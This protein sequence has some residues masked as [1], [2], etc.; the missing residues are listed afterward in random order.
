MLPKRALR[1]VLTTFLLFGGAAALASEPAAAVTDNQGTPVLDSEEK[2]FVT[3]INN[4]RAA[5]GLGTLKVSLKLTQAAAWMS[6]DLSKRPASGFGHIDSLLRTPTE[7]MKALGYDYNTYTG[8]NIAAGTKSNSGAVAFE[9]WRTSPGHDANMRNPNY[10]TMGVA[11]VYR[12][13]SYYG[14]YWTNDFGGYDDAQ[15]GEP[16]VVPPLTIPPVRSAMI[17]VP[18]TRILDTRGGAPIDPT[19]TIT[20][21]VVGKNNVPEKDVSAVT[22]T[23]TITDAQNA[24]FVTVYPAGGG[25]PQASNLNVSGPGRTVANLVTVPVG[26]SGD[27]VLYT[28]GGGHLLADVAGYYAKLSGNTARAGRFQPITPTRLLDTRGS[29]AV[30]PGGTKILHV[31]GSSQVPRKASAVSINLTVTNAIRSGFLTAY[32][33]ASLVPAVSNLNINSAGDTVAGAAIVPVDANGNI[34]VYLDGGGDLIVDINGWFTD[35]SADSRSEG[36]FIAQN[37][38]RAVDTRNGGTLKRRSMVDIE[39]P[40]GAIAVSANITLTDTSGAGF[41]SAWAAGG[42]IPTVSSVNAGGPGQTVA[43]HAIIPASAGG[44]RFYAEMDTDLIL[45]YDG[46]YLPDNV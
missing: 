35:D 12:T 45:D 19:G 40:A 37:P 26:P 10:T 25:R 5:N 32:P 1:V 23:V 17:A 22:L 33:A 18:P 11:R 29:G 20:L 46:Y 41:V 4:Y 13:G 27:V 7:R 6:E 38:N 21:H 14:W 44:S 16:P 8:E 36:L 15:I 3:L 43:N 24:G 30:A 42:A 31:A 9:Q 39:V 34:G 2:A 28:S